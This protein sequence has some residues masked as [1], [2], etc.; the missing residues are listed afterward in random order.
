MATKNSKNAK[1]AA[2]KSAPAK[3]AAPAVKAPIK[4]TAPV[5]TAPPVKAVVKPELKPAAKP[6]SNATTTPEEKKMAQTKDQKKLELDQAVAVKETKE[7]PKAAT[8]QVPAQTAAKAAPQGA[9]PAASP[10]ELELLKAASTFRAR[11]LYQNAQGVINEILTKF[12][13]SKLAKREQIL[14]FI[15]VEDFVKAEQVLL[16]GVKNLPANRW[17]W[18]TLAMVRSRTGNM[19]G[20]IEAL[21]KALELEHED[22]AARRLFELQRDTKDLNGALETVNLLRAKK[23]GVELEVAQAKLLSLLD[24]KEES[25]AA[26]EK[27]LERVP[28]IPAAVEQW[29]ALHLADKNSPEVVVERMKK[30]IA[31]GRD[32]ACLYHALSR[33]L[34][35]MEKNEESV[36]ALKKALGMNKN[37]VQWWYDL[38]V[39]QRQMGASDDSQV[40]LE[41]ALKLDPYN[42]TTL[43]V[44]GVEHK[45]VY[46]DEHYKRVNLAHSLVD[47]YAPEKKVELHFAIAKA[48]EDVGELATAFK[49]YEAAGKAQA[50][51]LPYS[52]PAAQGLMNITRDRMGPVTYEKFGPERVD[53]DKAVFVLGMPRSGTSLTEQIIASHPET[54][55]AGELKLLHRALDGVSVNGRPILTS[56]DQG[57]IPTFIP[58]VDLANTRA[59]DFKARGELYIKAIESLAASAGR[60]E[61]KRIVDKMPGNYFWTGLI[62][63][64]LPNAHVIHTQR[65]PLDNCLS[66]YRI[67]FPDGMPWSYDL[68]NLAKVYRSYY[69]HMQFWEANLPKDFMLTV[70]Y[71]NLVADIDTYAHKIISHMG[72]DWNENCLKFHETE[73]PV[74]TASLVQ[75]RQPL[76]STSVGRWKKYEDYLKPLIQELQPI[77]TAY[78]SSLDPAAQAL[79]TPTKK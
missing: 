71:E 72:L 8:P 12:P 26:C 57:A 56:N 21:K 59:L 37:Q 63:F 39:I 16:N 14:L 24:K 22:S 43:R 17:L 50:K 45:Y 47:I 73:R 55:G 23:D 6:I 11:G 9:V 53:S 19:P 69:E 5:K 31:A 4:T 10:A 2:A 36:V 54:H 20:E 42:P 51:I 75:V 41:E 34:H 65:H 78:E 61:A 79:L 3:K 76:Y 62:P 15:A 18:I 68:R 44:H 60:P 1:K 25:L 13:E 64:I 77:I 7:A 49:H 67:Y 38:A 70:K 74:K 27:L 66:I 32:E 28:A 30:M 46:G 58:G 35:R 52:H 40:S 33:G 48:A 29:V